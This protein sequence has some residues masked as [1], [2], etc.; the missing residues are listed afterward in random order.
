MF[1]KFITITLFLFLFTGYNCFGQHDTVTADT[2]VNYAEKHLG[3]TYTW[4]GTSPT[5]GFDCSGLV[6]HVFQKFD[7]DVPRSSRSYNDFGKEIPIDSARAGDL[8]L[9]TGTNP[10]DRCVGH[11]GIV[12]SNKKGK[13]HFIHSSSSQKHYGVCITEYY[14]SGYPKRFIKIVRVKGVLPY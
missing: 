13:L 2:I 4:G 8:I 3:T 1:S 11:L 14:G 5:R 7:I 6:Y 12:K 10:T 9:F